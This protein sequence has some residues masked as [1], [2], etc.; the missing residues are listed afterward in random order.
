MKS[1]N[2]SPPSLQHRLS[3]LLSIRM[4]PVKCSTLSPA[5]SLSKEKMRLFPG[6]YLQQ[7]HGHIV[8]LGNSRGKGIDIVA[9]KVQKLTAPEVVR[10]V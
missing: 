6:V 2:S 8:K 9:D 3:E 4:S 5:Q 1:R 10:A 7:Q